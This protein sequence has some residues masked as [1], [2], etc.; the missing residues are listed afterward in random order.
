[1]AAERTAA[2][3]VVFVAGRAFAATHGFQRDSGSVAFWSCARVGSS[4]AASRALS[5]IPANRCRDSA[6]F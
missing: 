6:E 5:L 4:I 1:M 2:E 3:T